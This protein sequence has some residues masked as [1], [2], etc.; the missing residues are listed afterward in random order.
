VAAQKF[1]KKSLK[2]D[3]FITSTERALEYLQRNATAV[4]VGLLVVVVLLVGGS[5]LSKGRAAA[6]VEASYMLYQGQT[7]LTQGEY[8]MAMGPLQDCI[9]KHGGSEFAKYA[10][11]NLVQAL[12]D[13]GDAE[14]A[15]ARLDEYAADIPVGHPAYK[16]MQL[17]R[18][19]ALADA[20]RPGEAADA[21]APLITDELSDQVYFQRTVRQAEFLQEAGR[22][23]EALALLEGLKSAV[24]A[25]DRQVLG[26]ELDNRIEV[27]RI[28]SR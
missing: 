4:G 12:I 3:S 24:A 13:L 17:L 28:L 21:L 23:Q 16:N 6:R 22:G 10:R 27:A 26:D 18:V 7:L 2:Q 25:G 5:Y 15:L 19:T 11:L 8:E 14:G 9:E 1:T 20:G